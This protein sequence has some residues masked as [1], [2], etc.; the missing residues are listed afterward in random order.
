MQPLPRNSTPSTMKTR[1][2]I[3]GLVGGLQVHLFVCAAP[4]LCTVAALPSFM[5]VHYSTGS[6]IEE[7]SVRSLMLCVHLPC[8]SRCLFC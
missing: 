5:L 6:C 4:F 8:T 3:M 2:V 1:H 7:A